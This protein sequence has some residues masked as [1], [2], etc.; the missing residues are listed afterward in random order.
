MKSHF[1]SFVAVRPAPEYWNQIQE[2]RLKYLPPPDKAGPHFTIVRPFFQETNLVDCKKILEKRTKKLQPFNLKLTTFKYFTM[3]NKH[4]LYLEPEDTS[5]LEKIYKVILNTFPELSEKIQHSK[6]VAHLSMGEVSKNTD[7]EKL[8]KQLQSNWKEI[9]FEV[10]EL[11]FL[12]CI[13]NLYEVREVVHL[14]ITSKTST[15]TNNKTQQMPKKEQT[16]TVKPKDDFFHPSKKEKKAAQKNAKDN[17]SKT[18]AKKPNAKEE[19]K[20]KKGKK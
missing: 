10:K 18:E 8:I 4:V 15:K 2:V 19:A 17:Q 7:V 9:E 6:F 13:D 3:K 1:G 5:P 12:T 16:T 14:E 20:G 11:Y